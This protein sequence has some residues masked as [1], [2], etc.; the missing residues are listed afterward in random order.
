MRGERIKISL[1]TIFATSASIMVSPAL[2]PEA[3]VVHAT[4]AWIVGRHPHGDNRFLVAVFGLP[5][6]VNRRTYSRLRV[7]STAR[8]YRKTL[9]RRPLIRSIWL[10]PQK[11]D[12]LC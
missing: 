8:P 4:P 6:C 11:E 12:Q 2:G 1:V 9:L 5:N 3:R 10:Q 7:F